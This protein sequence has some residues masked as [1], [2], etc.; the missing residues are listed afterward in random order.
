[1][2][3][4][5]HVLEELKNICKNGPLFPGDTI[6][7]ITANECVRRGWA[8]RNED[9]YFTATLEGGSY[10]HSP[11]VQE[12]LK[13]TTLAPVLKESISLIQEE[14][15]TN[16]QTREHIENVRNLLNAMVRE[17]LRRGEIHDQ[18]KLFDPERQTF[19]EFTSKLKS[20]TYGSDEYKGYL[21]AMEPALKHHYVNNRHHPEH[22]EN[23]II[24]M[25]LVDLLEMLLDWKAA[26]MRHSNG[27][28]EKSLDIN[29]TRFGMSPELVKIFQNTIRDFG[30]IEWGR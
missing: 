23:G 19:V 7:H 4:E 16:D 6:S 27:D 10:C 15:A 8:V 13:D 2:L 28:L 9:G 18:S 21:K 1:M 22:F 3:E 24:D 30:L 25:N 20:S 11:S 12:M 29:A 14:R 5:R 26:T 17:L